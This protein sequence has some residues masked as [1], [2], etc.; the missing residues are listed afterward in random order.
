VVLTLPLL[1]GTDGV[2]KMSKSLGNYIG[3]TDP[4]EEIFG[5]TMS[6][7]D[8]LILKYFQLI[9]SRSDDELTGIATRLE[10]PSTNP[11]HVKRELAID[12]VTQFHDEDS[13]Q[14]AQVHFDRIHVKHDV[15]ESIDEID[16]KSEDGEL[17]II[18][19]LTGSGL[20][21]SSGEARRM[22]KQGAVSVDGERVSDIDTQLPKK[23]GPYTIKV[24]KRKFMGVVVK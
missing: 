14:K 17:W 2:E 20:C 10:D 22:V 7:P 13:A 16:L 8:S 23:K 6:I 1:E 12:V 4:P 21:K 3:I 19:A 11:S 15:P 9:T 5:K 24:G 18:K